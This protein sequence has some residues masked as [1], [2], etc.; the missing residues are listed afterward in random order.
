MSEELDLALQLGR[1]SIRVRTS[2]PRVVPNEPASRPAAP[3][4]PTA[5]ED[6]FVLVPGPSA[7][8]REATLAAGSPAAASA[9]PL[10]LSLSL[11]D[12]GRASDPPS[13]V[14]GSAF[15]SSAWPSSPR[16]AAATP[17]KAPRPRVII[18]SCAPAAEEAFEPP[19][20]DRNPSDPLQ[21][22]GPRV[23]TEFSLSDSFPEPPLSLLDLGRHLSGRGSDR[24]RRAW[25]AGCWAKAVLDNKVRCPESTP[26]L[27]PYL[28]NSFYCVLRGRP[29]Q[30][31]AV[32]TSFV[33]FKAQVG[34]LEGSNTVTHGFAS[35]AEARAYFAAAALPFPRQQ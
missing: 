3:N 1:L 33:S 24:I 7:S 15:A 28:K 10:S 8:S 18:G 21:A 32:H 23:E 17:P 16:L 2:P 31:P 5:S 29:G 30:E 25:K 26:P 27:Q 20:P 6:S 22:P 4:S 34:R 9:E 35:E 19:R 13:S 12:I 11:G 14:S